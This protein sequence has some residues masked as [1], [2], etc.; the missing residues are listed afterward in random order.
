MGVAYISFRAFECVFVSIGLIAVLAI[1]SISVAY[2]NG[3]FQ[4]VDTLQVVEYSFKAIHKWCF[5]NWP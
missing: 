5:Y 4:S 3:V 1:L 2:S